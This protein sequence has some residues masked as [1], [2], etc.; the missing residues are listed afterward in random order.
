M[1]GGPSA[2]MTDDQGYPVLT[3]FRGTLDF[4]KVA[5]IWNDKHGRSAVLAEP[6]GSRMGTFGYDDLLK[7]GKAESQGFTVYTLEFWKANRDTEITRY[8]KSW[9]PKETTFA[10]VTDTKEVEHRR[11]LELPE[12]GAV[13]KSKI[14]Q[15]YKIAAKRAHPDAGGSDDAFKTIDRC[16][17]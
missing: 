2:T 11:L 6:F 4:A 3:Q 12:N 1:G 15:A 7:R 10:A 16:Q 9:F 13:L 17:G 8:M 14:E 5:R